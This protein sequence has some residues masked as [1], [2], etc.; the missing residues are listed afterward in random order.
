[1]EKYLKYK[2]LYIPTGVD[3]NYIL[4]PVDEKSRSL[5]CR[6]LSKTP[7]KMH[8]FEACS[9]IS[10]AEC[11][12]S[13]RNADIA[14]DYFLC[15]RPRSST[16][17][18]WVREFMGVKIPA[19]IDEHYK[20]TM[21]VRTHCATCTATDKD[22][23]DCTGIKCL[24]CI[25]H[26]GNES[27][28]RK[29]FNCL[30]QKENDETSINNLNNNT[31]ENKTVK[32]DTSKVHVDDAIYTFTSFHTQG[33]ECYYVVIRFS[34]NRDEADILLK[35]LPLPRTVLWVED[36]KDASSCSI[37]IPYAL[38]R[39]ATETRDAVRCALDRLS[40]KSEVDEFLDITSACADGRKFA[41]PFSTM[42]D[43][44]DKAVLDERWGYISFM[45]RH[46]IS[47][48]AV[49]AKFHA[50][51]VPIEVLKWAY[52]LLNNGDIDT[53]GIFLEINPFKQK[54]D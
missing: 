6:M 20:A 14:A 43:V 48:S 41:E 13:N 22:G 11:I 49:A 18:G 34:T 8:L 15:D 38:H 29:Y 40:K 33:M 1:M 3:Q 30:K 2:N 54:E 21:R 45:L 28:A 4:R 9:G 53:S 24:D 35:D 37:M 42:H 44:W 31:K 5:A 12:C 50:S 32:I 46:I 39:H 17:P 7:G 23:H 52:Q 16:A 25:L 10:C 26:K 27:I 51:G 19:N 47:S 36:R